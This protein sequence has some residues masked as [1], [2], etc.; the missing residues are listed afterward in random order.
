[1]KAAD[2]M[3]SNVITVT[4]EHSVRDVAQILLTR[5]ISGVP[6]LDAAG[7]LVG[8]VTESDLMRRAEAG[9]EHHRSW[10]LRLL[11]GRDG[12]AAEYVKEHSRRVADVM[13]VDIIS[14]A[15]DTPIRDVAEL[16]ERHGI[17]R[18]PVVKDRKLVGLI[19]RANLLEIL[20]RPQKAVSAPGDAA[21]YDAVMATFA[22]E[23][24]MHSAYVNVAVHDGTVELGGIVASRAEKQALRVAAE[25]TP[26]VRAVND[27]IVVRAIPVH[28]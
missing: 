16:L 1:M 8:I 9:T 27:R 22:A 14:A 21:L 13:T 23:P 3:V 2:I 24:W 25:E 5:R 26:G 6:V 18:V 10:W 28:V 7:D 15:P 4:P 20:T 12:L 17:K 19:S 11:M